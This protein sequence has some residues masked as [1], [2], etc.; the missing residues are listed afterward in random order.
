MYTAI[1]RCTRRDGKILREQTDYPQALCVLG[2]IDAGLG[3]K[4]DR[5]REGLRAVELVSAEK[6]AL[7]RVELIKYLAMIYSWAGQKELALNQLKTALEIPGPIS[8]GQL[9]LHPY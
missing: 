8:C 2:M 9:R 5:S 1:Y 3:R 6:D 7:T 4:K